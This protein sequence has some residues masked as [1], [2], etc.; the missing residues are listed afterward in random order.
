MKLLSILIVGTVL[1][2]GCDQPEPSV[3]CLNVWKRRDALKQFASPRNFA[4]WDER[5]RIIE[6]AEWCDENPS[7]IRF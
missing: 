3:Q 1:A 5:E 7:G 6:W 4:E 2:A